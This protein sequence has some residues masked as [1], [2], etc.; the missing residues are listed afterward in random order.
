MDMSDK[1]FWGDKPYFSLDHYLKQTFGEKVYRL[2]LN[3]GM[4][5]PNRDGTLD[6][7]GCIFCQ[8]RWKRRFCHCPFPLCHRAD[9]AGER[10]HPQEKVT[11]G[12]LSPIFRHIPI[13]MHQPVIC[14]GSLPKRFLI[15]KYAF[16]LSQRV[17]IAFHLKSLHCLPN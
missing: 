2:S 5:C 6:S 17:R 13:P 4:T 15:Q 1:K 16:Y 11:A 12:S 3:G 8:R 10:T 14:A 9:H 7:R